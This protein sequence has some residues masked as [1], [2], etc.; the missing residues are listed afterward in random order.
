MPIVAA[1][2]YFDDDLRAAANAAGANYWHV[3]TEEICRQMGLPVTLVNRRGLQ[4]AALAELTVLIL[5]DLAAKYLKSAEKEALR[6]WVEQGGLLIGFATEGLHELFGIEV[7]ETL[8]QPDDPF[9]PTCCFRF[10]DDELARPLMPPNAEDSPLLAISPVKKLRRAEGRELARLLTIFGRDLRRPAIT[11]REVGQGQTLYFCFNVAQTVWALHHGR[12]ILDDYDGDGKLRM[13]D[14]M[15]TRPFPTRV[16]Y[17]DM[18]MYLLRNV[19]ARRG[20]VFIHA[21]PPTEQGD[22]PD[23]L[24]HYGGDDEGATELQVQASVIMRDLGLPYHINLMPDPQG[25]FGLSREEFDQLRT[26]GTEP[27]LHFNFV[28]GVVHPFAFDRCDIQRQVDWYVAAFGEVPVC[29]VF[30]CTTWCGWSEPAE[31]LAG[32]GI[33]ADNSRFL[34][35]CP[36]VN[37]VNSVGFG[38]GTAY[39]YFHYSD[40]RKENDRIKLLALPIGGY[41]AGYRGAAVDFAVLCDGLRLAC[42]WH[43]PLNLFYHPVYVVEYPACREALRL[44]LEYIRAEG[45]RILHFGNDEFTRWWLAR[46][47]SEVSEVRRSDLEVSLRVRSDWHTGCIVQLQWTGEAP[48]ASA[49]DVQCPAV[50]REE[51]GTRWLYVAVPPGEHEVRVSAVQ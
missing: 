42:R 47:E 28:D 25:N 36:P 14:A 31:W 8:S 18:L 23:A 13:S 44:A 50:V 48:M 29:T 39:P 45:L 24:L 41:E 17:A 5:P 26:N 30:H 10:I 40:W 21:L 2:V 19:V 16:P 9:T 49:G 51:L 33:L 46:C 34:Q 32:A 15:V 11:L 43:L 22:V 6:E 27:S 20:H 35:Y 7:E 3:Y 1:A 37:P 12:P 4:P 38:F